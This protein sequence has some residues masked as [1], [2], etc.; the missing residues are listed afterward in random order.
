VLHE[1]FAIVLGIYVFGRDFL[2]GELPGI[3]LF[4]VAAPVLCAYHVGAPSRRFC[5]NVTGGCGTVRC[6]EC[7]VVRTPMDRIRIRCV[8]RGNTSPHRVP[9]CDVSRPVAIRPRKPV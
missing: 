8:C 1:G 9:I 3:V 6:R 7:H 2:A 5:C 4:G